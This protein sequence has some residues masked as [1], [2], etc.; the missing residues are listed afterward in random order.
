M[1]HVLRLRGRNALSGFRLN[2]LNQILHAAQFELAGLSAEYWHFVSVS[3]QL[4]ADEL[5]VLERIL[6]Y[7]AASSSVDESGELFLTVP[8][9]GTISPWSSKATDIARHCG[10]PAILRIERGTAWRALKAGG[11]TLS[12]SERAILLPLIHDRMTE[13]VLPT[14]EDADRLFEVQSPRPLK[15]IPLIA[16]GV[17]ALHQ[18]NR[19][20]GL[21]LSDDEI[22][23]L[24][25]YYSRIK[26]DPSDV[27]LMMFAQANSEHCRH[28]IFNADWTIDGVAQQ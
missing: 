20:M 12:T 6:T 19:E 24:R 4:T 14:V 8:R 15:S 22:E 18:A 11:G 21:A 1:P 13:T 26:R 2:K 5:S 17:D 9:L 7:G 25:N 3:R 28:K 16:R 10:L 27:E 23:Y